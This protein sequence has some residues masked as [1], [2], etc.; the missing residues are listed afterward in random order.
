MEPRPTISSVMLCWNRVALSQRCLASYRATVSVPHELFVVDNASTDETKAWVES[1]RGVPGIAAVTHME[2]NDPAVA[3]NGALAQCRGEL[4]HIMENDYDYLPGWDRYVVDRFARLPALGQLAPV[5]GDDYVRAGHHQGLVYLARDNVC[6]TSFLRREL[7]F[8]V[9][10]RVRGHYRG[11]CYPDDYHLSMQ[12]KRAGRLVAW[13]DVEIAHH[14]GLD[15]DEQS[16]DPDYYIR[17]YALKLFS[18]A[19]LRGHIPRWL[20]LDFHDTARLVRRLARVVG[21]KLGRRS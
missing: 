10:V 15:L 12:V 11:N 19:R 18:A 4:L 20:R 2:R 5:T 21:Y 3:L 16:R 13:S 8:D 17:D 9:G 1:L 6:T 7:F 14:I